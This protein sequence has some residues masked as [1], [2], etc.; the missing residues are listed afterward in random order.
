MCAMC[1]VSCGCPVS[2]HHLNCAYTG[3]LGLINKMINTMKVQMIR[4][5]ALIHFLAIGS[6]TLSYSQ[7]E[8]G[9]IYSPNLAYMAET[10]IGEPDTLY[11]DYFSQDK[12]MF[13]N[14]L[15]ISYGYEINPNFTFRI[16]LCYSTKG[17]RNING[18]VNDTFSLRTNRKLIY[19]YASFPITIRFQSIKENRFNYVLESGIVYNRFLNMRDK[20][21]SNLNGEVT[22]FDQTSDWLGNDYNNLNFSFILAAGIQYQ[23]NDC[24]ILIP[25]IYSDVMLTEIIN[26]KAKHSTVK[27]YLHNIGLMVE[28]IYRL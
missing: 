9:V 10:H 5:I 19:R 3:P 15:G 21:V 27:K 17:Y 1:L 25:T 26:R 8:I 28:I 6:I 14:R 23:I 16:G 24:L 7:S 11:D 4:I 22:E 13:G 18:F 20:G 2:A 12:A